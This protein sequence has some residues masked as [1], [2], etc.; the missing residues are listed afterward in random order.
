MRRKPKRVLGGRMSWDSDYVPG[1]RPL[2][3]ERVEA[4]SSGIMRLLLVSAVV[5]LLLAVAG[6]WFRFRPL[7]FHPIRWQETSGFDRGRMLS[8][9]L[10]QADFVG[11]TRAE[12]E[13]Y[14]GRPDF[15]E[16]QFW[17][18][19]GRDTSG[20]LP[21][22]RA[23][24]GDPGRLYAVFVHDAAGLIT[25]VLYSL[26]RPIFGSEPFDSAG[27]SAAD[28]PARRGMFARTLRKLRA[29]GMRRGTI[30]RLLGPPDGWRVR[31]H[32][33]VGNG[34]AFIGPKK[35]LIIEY[36]ADGVVVASAVGG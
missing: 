26:R 25:N 6:V 5:L 19:L 9:L 15:D 28:A 29:S 21:D 20:A 24:I 27:W 4:P 10:G 14:L 17:Y 13:V 30:Q 22:A 23:A 3:E 31:A 33:D 11:F 35:A 36:D 12:V 32:Y 34:G 8:S 18:D 2:T 7:T 1:R 16:R